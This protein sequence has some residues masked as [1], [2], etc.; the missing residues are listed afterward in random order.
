MIAFTRTASVAPGKLG[1]AVAFAR[2]IA[3][4]FQKT[5]DV[6]LE[7]LM[8][9]GGNP[10]RISWAARYDS[11]ATWES[12]GNKML[13]DPVYMAMVTQGSENFIAG[14][15]EDSIWRTL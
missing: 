1:S 2:E 10:N 14:S 5:Y 6:K 4:H 9:I 13:A 8:P 3:A 7:V 15:V 12:L 11:L